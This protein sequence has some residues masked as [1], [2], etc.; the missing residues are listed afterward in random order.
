MEIIS[1]INFQLKNEEIV[2]LLQNPYSKDNKIPSPKVIQQIEYLK[3]VALKQIQPRA[4]YDFFDPAE[5]NNYH[6]FKQANKT[7][8][9]VCT[10]GQPIVDEISHQMKSNNLS[11]AV[12]L[13]AI[14]SHAAEEV[15][16]QVNQTVLEESGSSLS[17]LPNSYRFSPGYCR[18]PLK[19]GQTLIFSRL[20][21]EKIGVSL[22][23]SMMMRPK[24]SVSFAIN[25]GHNID[26][27]M[28]MRKCESCDMFHCQ[29]RKKT[30]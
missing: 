8:L 7:V 5:L 22:T 1:S 30:T 15:A 10:I 16:S 24:K 20:H 27:Q 19:E 2:R 25:F 29:F 12:I 4:L 9:A 18:W 11:K 26:T 21:T 3:S 13:D 17:G 14:A 6:L 28:G 23:Q